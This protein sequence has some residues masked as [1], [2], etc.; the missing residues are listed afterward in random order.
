MRLSARDN[1][2]TYVSGISALA[3][4]N[5]FSKG[6]NGVYS[7]VYSCCKYVYVP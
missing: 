4:M 2:F 3:R 7:Y 5:E 1:K 6:L